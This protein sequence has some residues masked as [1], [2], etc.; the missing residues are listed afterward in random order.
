MCVVTR[1]C[2]SL[3]HAASIQ[4][5]LLTVLNSACSG[6]LVTVLSCLSVVMLMMLQARMLWLVQAVQLCQLC[7]LA[8]AVSSAAPDC[9]LDAAAARLLQIM[10]TPAAWGLSPQLGANSST[11]SSSAGNVGAYGMCSPQ[12]TQSSVQACSDGS[13]SEGCAT[14]AAAA[15]AAALLAALRSQPLPL[16]LAS[17]RCCQ[18]HWQLGQKQQQSNGRATSP[19]AGLDASVLTATGD[20]TAADDS[21]TRGCFLFCLSA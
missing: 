5:G 8:T 1:A 13:H 16:L 4:A 6:R 11:S 10:T 21:R 19:G 20:C 14:T 3:Q 7:C 12:C 15:A 2:G 9:V 17:S 18:Q